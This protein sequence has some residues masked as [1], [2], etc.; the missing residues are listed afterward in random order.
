MLRLLLFL[1][2]L[3][4]LR[5]V[6]TSSQ[7]PVETPN[8]SLSHS[9]QTVGPHATFHLPPTDSHLPTTTC[10]LPPANCQLPPADCQLLEIIFPPY[11]IFCQTFFFRQKKKKIQH[12]FCF[13][14]NHQTGPE[15]P[16][17]CSQR[18]QPYAG[19]RKKPPVGRLFF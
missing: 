10:Q 6:F 4:L 13:T 15:G 17:R 12:N 9:P 3:L 8:T 14:R 1:L 19:T 18:L 5:K 11:I 7:W 16:H 2:L